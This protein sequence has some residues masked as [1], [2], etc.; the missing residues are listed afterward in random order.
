[1]VVAVLD[2]Y[3]L[4]SLV[5]VGAVC[6]DG[7]RSGVAFQAPSLTSL[8]RYSRLHGQQQKGSVALDAQLP[9]PNRSCLCESRETILLYRGID[10]TVCARSC[11][12]RLRLKFVLRVGL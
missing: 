2:R 1:M 7:G 11:P 4:V 12:F 8:L 5:E 9:H 10:S 6:D 3:T